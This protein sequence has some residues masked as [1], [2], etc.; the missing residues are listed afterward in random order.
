M[1]ISIIAGLGNPGEKYAKT[2]HNVGFL[3]VDALVDAAG[4]TWRESSRFHGQIS[5]VAIGEGSVVVLKPSTYMN[6]SGRSL[7]AW[8]RFHNLGA[9]RALIIY[10]DI[11]LDFGRVK[12]SASGSAGGHNGIASLLSEA[13]EGFHRYR[14]GIGAKPHKAMDLADYV[15]SHLTADELHLL[16]ERMP[17][18]LTQIKDIIT[19]GPERAMIQINQ[20][21]TPISNSND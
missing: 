5:R 7:S 16:D 13:G 1:S 9:Q 10:D 14:I 20:K 12:L 3:L 18:Y 11:T 4:A 21:Q 19:Q 15:L 6:D 2:R 17:N 8:L